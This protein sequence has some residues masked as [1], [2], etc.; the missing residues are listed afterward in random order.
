[1]NN[2]CLYSLVESKVEYE[3]LKQGFFP[4]YLNL[5]QLILCIGIQI[6]NSI[7]PRAIPFV[8]ERIPNGSIF[9]QFGKQFIA[10]S[11]DT[12]EF[13][14]IGG[15]RDGGIDGLDYSWTTANRPQKTIYQF[16]IEVDGQS[17]INKTLTRLKTTVPDCNRL[18]YVT[19]QV[20]R[21]QHQ[22]ID[23]AS[24]NYNVQLVIYDQSWFGVHTNNSP[25]TV[26]V[27]Q[28]LEQQ[29][30]HAYERSSTF[31]ET[32]DVKDPRIY[33]YLRQQ[34]EN[35]QQ[36]YD[37]DQAIHLDEILM[38]SLILFALEGTDPNLNILRSPQEIQRRI[39]EITDFNTSWVAELLPRRLEAL[40]TKP[41]RIRHHRQ[42]NMYCLPHETRLEIAERNMVD[43]ALLEHFKQ[44][45]SALLEEKLKNEGVTIRAVNPLEIAMDVLHELF[46]KQGLE[47]AQFI[48]T[49][50]LGVLIDQLLN[51]VIRE[52]ISAAGIIPRNRDAVQFVLLETFRQI[53]YNGD[54]MQKEFLSKLSNTYNMLFLLQIDPTL[55]RYFE[56]IAG[57]LR[58]YVDSSILIPAIA[59]Y[60]LEP[61]N[62]RYT[63]LLRSARDAG[64]TILV[65]D[66]VLGE[67]ENH[68]RSTKYV[69]QKEF[70]RYE[71]LYTDRMS[72]IFID[73]ILIRA[74]FYVRINNKVETF[75]EFI[76]EFISWNMNG[77]I[78]GELVLW[79]EDQ[80]GVRYVEQEVALDPHEVERLTQA[81]APLKFNRDPNRARTDAKQLLTIYQLRK[82]NNETS[83]T[84]IFGYKT[85]WLTS[86]VTSQ[87]AFQQIA[88]EQESTATPYIR[89]DYIYNYIALAPSKQHV[90]GIYRKMFPTLLGVNVSFYV[91]SDVAQYIR[92]LLNEY[93]KVVDKPRFRAKLRELIHYLKS[94][95]DQVDRTTIKN[96]YDELRVEAE[97]YIP[98]AT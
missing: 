2:I 30:F 29:F 21:D 24:D 96:F 77:D 33:I 42:E 31:I 4:S 92:K 91:P 34:L 56:R 74:Y 58:I 85:W 13:I 22:L 59:E 64:I 47:F 80:F 94:S 28:Q 90:D 36:D 49:G 76:E 5:S 43:Q 48:A 83:Q 32:F 81:L 87:R 66:Y 52:K 35:K 8:L 3:L 71:H 10:A 86:D 7:D 17:K 46:H 69:Y 11:Q 1:M 38:D 57:E 19:N 79:L 72:I 15:T 61:H 6:M 9:E 41:R 68:L 26:Y 14:P 75:R 45:L 27:F 88:D 23:D 51:E 63:N 25:K 82:D 65:N 50:N 95:P 89:A 18:Y 97:S 37:G 67:I 44:S 55:A 16:S 93:E 60:F 84:G 39:L 53:V 54:Q 62:Q 98:R 40:S 70:E 78:R 73:Q 20:I 12:M